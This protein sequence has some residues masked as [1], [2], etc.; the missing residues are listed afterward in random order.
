MSCSINE[1][2]PTR[3]IIRERDLGIARL[4]G[5]PFLGIGGYLLGMIAL[6]LLEH[7]TAGQV[8]EWLKN[9]AGTMVGLVIGLLFAVPGWLLVF[10]RWR[11]IIDGTRR[12]AELQK[13]FLVA[14]T[15]KSVAA[16]DITHVEVIWEER[17]R[18]DRDRLRMAYMVKLMLKSGGHELIT[19][20]RELDEARPVAEK[21]AKLI[22]KDVVVKEFG[23][24]EE[25][26]NDPAGDADLA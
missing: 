13:D 15:R 8:I 19:W 4:F 6:G 21:I 5:L 17:N 16:Q 22:G 14:K 10:T 11:W 25:E 24:P 9:A 12:E 23:N 3:I 2:N 26:G 18:H 7:I 1:E 20:C